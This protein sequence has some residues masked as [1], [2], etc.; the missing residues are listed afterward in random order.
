MATAE[1]AYQLKGHAKFVDLVRLFGWEGLDRFWYSY[2]LEEQNGNL[3]PNGGSTDALL[4]RLCQSVGKDIRPL[5][6]FWGIPPGDSAALQAAIDAEGLLPSPEI[7]QRLLHYKSLV[8][9]DNAAFRAFALDWWN[10][11]PSINGNWTEREHARQWDTT[12][13]FGAGDQQRPNGEIYTEDSAT[14]IKDRVQELV[15]LYFTDHTA[16]ST[17]FTGA[18]LDD[19]DADLDGDGM[20][21]HDERVWG[22]DPTNPGSMSPITAPPGGSS[23]D[24]A[25]TRRDDALTGK[26]FAVWISTDLAHWTVDP[27]AVQDPGEPD[28]NNVET[29]GVTLS[30]GT[31]SHPRVFVRIRAE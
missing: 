25:Y 20:S 22:L 17:R 15:D 29:V 23:V 16:W 8:P 10:K 1:K 6:H 4:L 12:E 2:M 21:N 5:L 30:P 7:Y 9:A 18:D 28:A 11:Q 13:L 27:G 31:L 3:P 19:P 14:G 24:F 26:S